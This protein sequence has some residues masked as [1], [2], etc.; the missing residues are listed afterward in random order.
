VGGGGHRLRGE[1]LHSLS[2]EN[3]NE[4]DGELARAL[5]IAGRQGAKSLELRAAISLARLWAGRGERQRARNLLAPT[6]GWFTEGADTPDLKDA[7]ALLDQLG[8]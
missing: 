1:L 5:D 4:A 6:Y 3:D 8:T 2:R 7:R